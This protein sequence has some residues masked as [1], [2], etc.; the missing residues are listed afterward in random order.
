MIAQKSAGDS[1][2]QDSGSKP[3]DI[4]PAF[5]EAITFSLLASIK[6]SK[7][8]NDG[9]LNAD[10]STVKKRL[11]FGA[12]ISDLSTG[13]DSKA[14]TL[15]FIPLSAQSEVKPGEKKNEADLNV[16]YGPI[17]KGPNAEPKV[18]NGP[19]M[20]SLRGCLGH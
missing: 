14:H 17:G 20:Y 12:V 4:S 19:G 6:D 1:Q 5:E 16:A 9:G 3:M 2:T 13:Q 11:E 7:D 15:D 8:D 18:L 10:L